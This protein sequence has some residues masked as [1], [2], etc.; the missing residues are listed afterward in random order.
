[1]KSTKRIA[2]LIAALLVTSLMTLSACDRKAEKADDN[3]AADQTSETDTDTA[4]SAEGDEQAD[5]Q[6]SETE[7]GETA[8]T[9]VEELNPVL[10]DPSKATKQAPETFQA[11]FETTEGDFVI[12]FKREWAPNG[13]DRAY[14]L[15]TADYY[16]GLAFFRVVN[17][18]MAQFGIHSHPQVNEAWKEATI[19]ADPLVKS[20]KRG[21]VTFAQ[22]SDKTGKSD[23]TTRTTH[24]FINYSDNSALDQQQFV[25]VGEVVEGMDVVESLYSN[26]GGGPPTGPN[27]KDALE[28]G[29]PYLKA[30]FPELDYIKEVTIV[31]A[32][33]E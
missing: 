25:P 4:Q 26:Y 20:N 22:R 1:M 31:E 8:L 29:N 21:F 13:A 30:N 12:E 2:L 5:A 28:K 33:E 6:A 7:S 16:D 11:K 3:G 9:P 17:N 23:P 27:Q 14:N 24:L 15:I 10:L 18:F 32:Q 19:D